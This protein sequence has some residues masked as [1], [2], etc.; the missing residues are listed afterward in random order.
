MD[1]LTVDREFEDE[2]RR[3]MDEQGIER[4]D[5]IYQVALER[6]QVYG[7]G[8]LVCMRRLTS[9]ELRAIGLNHDPEEILARDL[10]RRTA[11]KATDSERD[12][13]AAKRS[14]AVAGVRN[15]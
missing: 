13:D 14:V 9:E 6:G 5:A 8:D 11:S 10:E 3:V 7:D 4:E 15:T 12:A 2:V 1:D